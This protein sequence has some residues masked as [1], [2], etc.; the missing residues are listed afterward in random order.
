[1][2]CRKS[3][4]F[5]P[6]QLAFGEAGVPAEFVGLAGL[7]KLPEVAEVLAY[8][9]AVA[10]PNAG[11]ALAR[12]LLGPR[13]RVGFKDLA[14]VAS[15]AKGRNQVL[16]EEDDP[17]AA[18]YLFAE[19]LEH[20][21]EVEGLSDEGRRR[22]EEFRAELASLR[23]EARA[24][25]AEFLAAVIRRTGLLAELDADLDRG[26][27]ETVKRNLA[28]F[29][30]EV[31]AFSPLEGE[32]TL[33]AF[34][35]YIDLVE[36]SEKQEWS[37]V[38]P[39]AEDSVKVMTIHQAKG[40]EFDTVFVPGLATGIL[41]D[42]MIQHN[43]AERG[44]SMDFELRGDAA[45][46]PRV[47]G[48]PVEVPR[49]AE[50]AGDDRGTPPLLR[51][52][53]A[54]A[55]AA[56]RDGGALVRRRGGQAE[57]ARRRSSRSWPT[58]ARR[59]ATRRS[60]AGRSPTRRTRWSATGSASSATGRGRPARTRPTPLFPE[61]WRR[62]RPPPPSGGG[63]NGG[64]VPAPAR[65]AW[66]RRGP[67]EGEEAALFAGEADRRRTLAAAPPRARGGRPPRAGPPGR[68]PPSRCRHSSTTRA[69][70]SASTGRRS[71]RS[72]GSAARPRGAAR[73]STRGSNAA[74]SDRRRCSSWTSRPTWRPTS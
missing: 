51:G 21:D 11:V 61:G 3:R 59:R 32:T 66:S 68:P 33:R 38:Q 69:A 54:R 19:A 62:P 58:G 1:M 9:R 48:E 41:P 71:G 5:E 39:S 27:A 13:Y 35:D 46:L 45:I 74:R 30:D 10:D 43:P 53:H 52:A 36:A 63:G 14:R 47:P 29:L 37:P 55:A 44:K 24:P 64:R 23:A 31:H 56:V 22:L 40:L 16:R 57:G 25:V 6:L 73:A 70:R 20:L 60:T 4:L 67:L 15:W 17:E 12:I 65:S 7:V 26:R 28:A 42:L 34:L 8:A 2:L 50:G 49:G 72:R 18:P